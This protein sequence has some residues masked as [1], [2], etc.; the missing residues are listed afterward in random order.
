MGRKHANCAHDK[1]TV[2]T[3]IINL[4]TVRDNDAGTQTIQFKF[5]AEKSTAGASLVEINSIELTDISTIDVDE[6]A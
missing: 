6:D 3:K 2:Y 5:D 1:T 4:D